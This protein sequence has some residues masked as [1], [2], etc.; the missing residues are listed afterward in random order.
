[1]LY[2]IYDI[3]YNTCNI[4]I[5]IY[6]YIYKYI[7]YIIYINSLITTIPIHF[8]KSPISPP[9]WQIGHLKFSLYAK[10]NRNT[11]VKLS[12]INTIHIKQQHKVGFFI[13]KFTLKYMVGNVYINKIHAKQ[14]L[15]IISVYCRE[16]FSH[17]FNCF[18]VSKEILHV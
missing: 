9:Y 17:P 3:S 15:Y 1:M 13:S 10:L 2:N 8:L 5:Y 12:S 4:Y 18:V 11:T 14:C 6:I 7:Y 16:G